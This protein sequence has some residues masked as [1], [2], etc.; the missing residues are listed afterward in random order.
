LLLLNGPAEGA[1]VGLVDPNFAK[2][3]QQRAQPIQQTHP[4]GAIVH[5]GCVNSGFPYP[6]LGVDQD[7][8]LA[9][10]RA[11]PHY[12]FVAVNTPMLENHRGEFNALG[13][14]YAQAGRTLP[15]D[16][17]TLQHVQRHVEALQRTVVS[18]FVKI[19]IHRRPVVKLTVQVTPLPAGPRQPQDGIEDI[20]K[21][22][23]SFSLP[24]QKKFYNFPLAV[25]KP[26]KLRLRI[27]LVCFLTRYTDGSFLQIQISQQP[28]N[29][30]SFRNQGT[31]Q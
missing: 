20:S 27:L 8:P 22:K 24:V 4:S 9:S 25:G 7:L 30:S 31:F 26:F 13:V 1:S 12:L 15:V 5:I 16:V 2:P 18:P 6:T 10:A 17:K 29:V 21:V 23:F 3:G 28:L 19:I 11:A 14:S